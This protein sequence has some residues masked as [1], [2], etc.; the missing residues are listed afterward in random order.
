MGPSIGEKQ[1]SRGVD[2]KTPSWEAC[3]LFITQ[4][5]RNGRIFHPASA[6]NPASKNRGTDVVAINR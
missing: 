6:E 5:H 1:V 2:F 3:Q 4:E